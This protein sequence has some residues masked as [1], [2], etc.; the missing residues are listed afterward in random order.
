VRTLL[1]IAAVLVVM[2]GPLV[3]MVVRMPHAPD[4]RLA[5]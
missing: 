2:F 1:I 4:D 3:V 5:P